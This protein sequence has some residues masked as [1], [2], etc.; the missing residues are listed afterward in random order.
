MNSSSLLHEVYGTVIPVLQAQGEVPPKVTW[1]QYLVS[2]STCT[3]TWL[4]GVPSRTPCNFCQPLYRTRTFHFLTTKWAFLQ[5]HASLQPSQVES[6]CPV[7]VILPSS[8]S[9]LILSQVG[10]SSLHFGAFISCSLS[11]SLGVRFLCNPLLT[12]NKWVNDPSLVLL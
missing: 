6:A 10:L 9:S 8:R 5:A 3:D 11:T 1:M 2:S 7:L 4:S 12:T